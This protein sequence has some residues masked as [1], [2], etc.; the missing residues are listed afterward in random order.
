MRCSKLV[1][2]T[3]GIFE[4]GESCLIIEDVITTGGSILETVDILQKAGKFYHQHKQRP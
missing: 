2:S 4:A 1:Y 3:L